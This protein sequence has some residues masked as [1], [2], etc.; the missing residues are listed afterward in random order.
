VGG[1]LSLSDGIPIWPLTGL[2]SDPLGQ[3]NS[4]PMSIPDLAAGCTPENVVQPGNTQYLRPEC[5]INPLAPDTAFATANCDQNPP[6]GKDGAKVS[7]ASLGV[8]PLTCFNLL[9]KLPRNSIIGPGLFNVDMSFIKD[10]HIARI[11]EAFNIQF[12][13]E[14]FNILNHTNFAPP[15]NNLVALDPGPQDGFGV[16]DT[17]TQ[18][19]MREIQ[20]ALKI[21]W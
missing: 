14:F 10:N 11:S 21:I 9:G 20:F 2:G 7:L 16:I 17:P 19:P 15:S 5:F 3:L 8:D 18:V 12:R 4:E 1:L 13:A 6:L